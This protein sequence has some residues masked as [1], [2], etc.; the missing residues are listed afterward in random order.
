MK[1]HKSL[2]ELE[3][4]LAGVIRNKAN[5][6]IEL[7]ALQKNIAAHQ[8]ELDIITSGETASKPYWTKTIDS[9]ALNYSTRFIYGF[10][11]TPEQDSSFVF[12][13]VE[14]EN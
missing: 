13:R 6:E 1:F 10:S 9:G 7:D 3:K 4:K 11:N 14:Q 8:K 5:I 2:K 12:G